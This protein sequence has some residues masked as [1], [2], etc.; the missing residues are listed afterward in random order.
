MAG[1]EC[2]VLSEPG[3]H[4]AAVLG[5][6]GDVS[7]CVERLF[8]KVGVCFS[9]KRRRGKADTC[10]IVR[11]GDQHHLRQGE[12]GLWLR[13]HVR[14]V[15]SAICTN[16]LI[17]LRLA[18]IGC[19]GLT[20]PRIGCGPGKSTEVRGVPGG[21]RSAA[22]PRLRVDACT[23]WMRTAAGVR[24]NKLWLVCGVRIGAATRK[25]TEA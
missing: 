24:R 25:S 4:G 2:E 11:H 18:H 19:T 7:H 12:C 5:L 16:Q 9:A 1:G 14:R 23:R 20:G 13:R 21:L 17:D 22:R 10:D 3:C 15:A 6:P 8:S